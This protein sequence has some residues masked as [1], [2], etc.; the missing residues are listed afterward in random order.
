MPLEN[1]AFN[2]GRGQAY[3]AGQLPGSTYALLR[4]LQGLRIA[5]VDGAATG[6]DITLT[7]LASGDTIVGAIRFNFDAGDV[8]QLNINDILSDT[9]LEEE[10]ETISFGVNTTGDKVLVVWFDKV[11]GALTGMQ[12]I[13]SY[14]AKGEARVHG[15]LPESL[16]AI[17]LELQ[18][19]RITYGVG[20]G[21]GAAFPV[22]GFTEDDLILSVIRLNR[23]NA[24]SNLDLTDDTIS[25][26]YDSDVGDDNLYSGQNHTGDSVLVFWY[27][28]SGDHREVLAEYFAKGQARL[29]GQLDGS[30]YAHLKELQGFHVTAVA[31]AAANADI[32][33]ANLSAEDYILGVYHFARDTATASVIELSPYANYTI[34]DGVITP[35]DATTIGDAILIIW[36]DKSGR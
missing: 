18:N 2:F 21:A 31:G 11:G 35:T 10:P 16:Y 29:H 34:G 17:L 25:Y 22:A 36:L 6:T 7:G 12:E 9:Y 26:R 23:D 3:L 30:L 27:D 8:D 32:T 4:E 28:V 14:F 20:V 1:I 13:R 19:L 24:V 5:V 15:Q 33:V